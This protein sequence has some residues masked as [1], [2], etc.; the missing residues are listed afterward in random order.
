M[1][2]WLTQLM[3]RTND[4]NSHRALEQFQKMKPPVFVGEV[5]LLQAE[6]WLFQIEKILDVM[7][8]TDEQRVS[9]SSFMFQKKAEHWWRAV[10]SSVK[11]MR[12][13]ITWEFLVNKF[14]EKY[15]PETARDNMASEFL[16]LRQ[17]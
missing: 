10:K 17:S 15:I 16:E 6:G 4:N 1:P 3:T 8:C 9:F 12:E 11:S 5:D 13:P 14:T 7:N 2:E